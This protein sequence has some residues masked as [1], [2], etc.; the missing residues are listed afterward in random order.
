MLDPEDV[1]AAH[2][3]DTTW[4]AVDRDG[5]VAMFESGEAGAVP[6]AA[7]A[8]QGGLDEGLDEEIRPKVFVYGHTG[9]NWIAAAYEREAAPAKPLTVD[10]AP[11]AV[12][13]DA[14]RFEGRF[15]E[16]ATLQPVELWKCE[17]W[18]PAWLASD[19]RT[20]HA[21]PGREGEI[22][23]GDFADQ[24]IVWGEPAEVE[25]EAQR[26]VPRSEAWLAAAKA[27]EE[28]EA[29]WRAEWETRSR[30]MKVSSAQRAEEGAPDSN[31][32]SDVLDGEPPKRPAPTVPPAAKKP[33]WKRW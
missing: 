15:A 26:V 8:E 18:M 32:W 28:R 21:F 24:A 6:E 12:V 10:A 25:T 9:E 13:A 30:E 23:A 20:A 19:G 33:W 22:E 3:M 2:S 16:T 14:I 17:S 29:A 1:P 4:F 31:D 7:G 5:N 11:E 27:A